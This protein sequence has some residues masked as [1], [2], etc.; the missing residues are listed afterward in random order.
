VETHH[1]CQDRSSGDDPWEE[2]VLVLIYLFREERVLVLIYLFI[3][4][5]VVVTLFV[6]TLAYFTRILA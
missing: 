1:A 5:K 2:R 6:A 3:Y 4:L